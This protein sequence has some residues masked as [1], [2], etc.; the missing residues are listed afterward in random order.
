MN[1]KVEEILKKEGWIVECKS[2]LE[3]RHED[4]GGFASL[5]A[6]ELII[7]YFKRDYLENLTYFDLCN[8]C[9][10]EFMIALPYIGTEKAKEEA[11]EHILME[12]F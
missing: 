3:I 5:F 6:A 7:D 9:K 8:L 1:K 11:I 2:P 4:S 12:I 10:R